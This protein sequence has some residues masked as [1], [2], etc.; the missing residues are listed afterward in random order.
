MRDLE[1]QYIFGSDGQRIHSPH[2]TKRW[3]NE[4]VQIAD[5][6]YLGFPVSSL[7]SALIRDYAI[8]STSTMSYQLLQTLGVHGRGLP[9][10][11]TSPC[12]VPRPLPATVTQ[13]LMVCPSLSPISLPDCQTFVEASKRQE[14]LDIKVE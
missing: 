1:T 4:S 7:S 11:L 12:P 5:G 10:P 2:Y 6:C 13:V 3:V 8:L 9:A 14:V